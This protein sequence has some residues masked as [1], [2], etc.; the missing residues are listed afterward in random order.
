MSVSHITRYLCSSWASCYF[1][2]SSACDLT[3]SDSPPTR[4]SAQDPLCDRTLLAGP[5]NSHTEA[6]GDDATYPVALDALDGELVVVTADADGLPLVRDERTG[7]DRAATL[8]TSET[9]FMPL[10]RLVQ[11]LLCTFNT[12]PVE[13]CPDICNFSISLFI[14]WSYLQ[15]LTPSKNVA[16]HHRE[17]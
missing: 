7:A 3:F 9:V 13:T 17:K 11:V 10:L 14:C 6:S 15:W 1:P 2:H 5:V 12:H 4:T 8:I 16:W